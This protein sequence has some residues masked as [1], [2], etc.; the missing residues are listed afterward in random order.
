MSRVL[1][2]AVTD[3]AKRRTPSNN[4]PKPFETPGVEKRLTQRSFFSILSQDSLSGMKNLIALLFSIAQYVKILSLGL[5]QLVKTT[6]NISEKL[7]I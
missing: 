4:C 7:N 5:I 3:S 6:T 2:I 1:C